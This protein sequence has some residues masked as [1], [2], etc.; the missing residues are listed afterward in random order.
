MCGEGNRIIV[1]RT[2]LEKE[3]DEAVK[4]AVED[5]EKSWEKIDTDLLLNILSYPNH[6]LVAKKA[7]YMY[8]R[9]E[10]PVRDLA[11]TVTAKL[12]LEKIQ[13]ATLDELKSYTVSGICDE[14]KY[15]RFRATIAAIEHKWYSESHVPILKD[16][17]NSMA[18]GESKGIVK[19][20]AEYFIGLRQSQLK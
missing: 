12:N 4:C 7:I 17:L 3:V 13:P 20:A 18:E 14:H 16:T 5:T 11:A 19:L 1:Q 2:G 8:Q 9:P 10:G 15:A 6:N